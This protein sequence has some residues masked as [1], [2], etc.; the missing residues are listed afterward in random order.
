MEVTGIVAE[1]NPFHLG[2]QYHL[3]QT[4]AARE[5]DGVIAVLSGCFTQRG[6]PALFDKWTRA[7]TALRGGVDLVLELPVAFAVRSAGHFARG[8]V[9]TLEACGVVTHLSCGVETAEPQ[10]LE[11]AARLLAE[12]P[13]A[14]RAA[15][16]RALDAGGSYPAALAYALET[17]GAAALL[18]APNDLLALH[19]LQSL[20][21]D[22]S[23]IVPVLVAR[24]G[25]HGAADTPA[26]ADGYASA[27]AVRRMLLAGDSAWQRHVPA[28]TAEI[29]LRQLRA[30]IRPLCIEDFAQI[31]L[32]LLRRA[33]PERLAQIIEIRE[34]LEHRILAAAQDAS[35]IGALCA[36]AKSKRYTYTRIQRALLHLLLNFTAEYD[37][38]APAYLRVLGFNETGARIL[39]AMR[40]KAQLPVLI[41]PAR[42]RALLDGSGRLLLEL[43]A[44]ATDL[45]F[46]PLGA[47]CGADFRRAPVRV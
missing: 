20:Y 16:R 10:A 29:L 15:L 25:S 36:A 37:R 41:R 11:H 12:E 46:V 39:K 13:P 6:E 23:S 32:A 45:Y 26:A 24:R 33:T 3:R 18:D 21:R 43:D 1:Y 34:G 9:R 7:E 4:R 31:L 30:G 47:P 17:Q 5:A 28:S 38:D 27:A 22:G 8:A 19:Y 2:H 40:K 44:R 35:T 42:Q 14:F